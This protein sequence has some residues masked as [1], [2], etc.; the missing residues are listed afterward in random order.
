MNVSGVFR[1]FELLVIILGTLLLMGACTRTTDN[2][3]E[4][5]KAGQGFVL[6]TKVPGSDD[7]PYISDPRGPNEPIE[8]PTPDAPHPI[9]GA[10][11]NVEQYIVQPGDTLGQIANRYGVSVDAIAEASNLS[12][13]NILSVGQELVIPPPDP[14]N[15]GPGFKII[16]DSEL[17]A[18]PVSA[19]F[20]TADF[21]ASQGG[22]L[23]RHEEEVVWQ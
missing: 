12:N 4:P 18:S 10:R 22:Y 16:P 11:T 19:Y 5:W 9:P 20:N 1:N 2:A 6:P 14:V 17:V 15:T 21:A 7:N 23:V 13:I 3:A 8:S